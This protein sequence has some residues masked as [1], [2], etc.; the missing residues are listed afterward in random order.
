MFLEWQYWMP[1]ADCTA[2]IRSDQNSNFKTRTFF[3]GK[4]ELLDAWNHRLLAEQSTSFFGI[5]TRKSASK[6]KTRCLKLA[7]GH[8]L[9]RVTMT[10]F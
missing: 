10:I 4:L 3:V 8:A 1:D 7:V 9:E 2:L 6:L 5:I